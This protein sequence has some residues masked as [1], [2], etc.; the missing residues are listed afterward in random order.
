MS[1]E[2][3]VASLEVAI[4]CLAGNAA[5]PAFDIAASPRVAFRQVGR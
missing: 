3:G 5:G 1:G 2:E 4:R